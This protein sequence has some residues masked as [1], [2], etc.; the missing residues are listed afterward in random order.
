MYKMPDLH[1]RLLIEHKSISPTQWKY[2]PLGCK[3][4]AEPII[5]TLKGQSELVKEKPTGEDCICTAEHTKAAV[6]TCTG[7]TTFRN[8]TLVTW[9]GRDGSLNAMKTDKRQMVSYVYKLFLLLFW[10]YYIDYILCPFS[11]SSELS[12]IPPFNS[13]GPLKKSIVVTQIMGSE[14]SP[15]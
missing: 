7:K 13:P 15:P 9:T 12:H 3:G 5:L 14:F 2:I 10:D 6:C 11:F 1:N 8:T 4:E